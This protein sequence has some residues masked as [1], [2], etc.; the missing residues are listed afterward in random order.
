MNFMLPKKIPNPNFTDF[1]LCR[2]TLTEIVFSIKKII[3]S[4]IVKFEVFQ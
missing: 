4:K 1:F 3:F 2:V